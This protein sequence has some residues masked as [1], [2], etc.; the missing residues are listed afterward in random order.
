MAATSS[1]AAMTTPTPTRSPYS[2]S[3]AP[4]SRFYGGSGSNGGGGLEEPMQRTLLRYA[5]GS[6][7]DI[8]AG[9]E[10][11][12]PRT[13]VAAG[14][15][16]SPPPRPGEAEAPP[17]K[18][19]CTTPALPAKTGPTT[20]SP[21][22]APTPSGAT[23]GV[24]SWLPFT[25]S[26]RDRDVM[27]RIAAKCTLRALQEEREALEAARKAAAAAPPPAP[28]PPPP[29]PQTIVL[30][31]CGGH[32]ER[33]GSDGKPVPVDPLVKSTLTG[34][35]SSPQLAALS[36]KPAVNGTGSLSSARPLGIS[37]TTSLSP[38]T[39]PV[40]SANV[41]APPTA[42]VPTSAASTVPL[43]PT[44]A[45]PTP[46]PAGAAIPPA[47]AAAVSSASAASIPLPLPSASV[48]LG[49]SSHSTAAS[50]ATEKERMLIDKANKYVQSLEEEVAHK[51]KHL[52]VAAHQLAEEESRSI[53]L[54]HDRDVLLALHH[55][56]ELDN[57]D[58][59]Q[60]IEDV[61]A[62]R[63]REY[64]GGSGLTSWSRSPLFPYGYKHEEDGCRRV[65]GVESSIDVSQLPPEVRQAYATP[66]QPL[67]VGVTEAVG[68]ER[69]GT[70]TA[71]PSPAF[72]P[73]T[74]PP[75]P[76]TTATAPPLVSTASRP[77]L[78]STLAFAN[79]ITPIATPLPLP[80]APPVAVAAPLQP[81]APPTVT[82]LIPAPQSY[83]PPAPS[84]PTRDPSD[85]THNGSATSGA[86]GGVM[87]Q[88]LLSH[89]HL[90]APVVAPTTSSSAVTWPASTA[91]AT[92]GADVVP[93]SNTTT[94]GYQS[95]R[96]EELE[97]Y[98][99]ELFAAA[100][101]GAS[102]LQQHSGQPSS[103]ASPPMTVP[104]PLAPP[105]GPLVPPPPQPWSALPITPS[106]SNLGLSQPTSLTPGGKAPRS[107]Q[108][109]AAFS[110]LQTDVYREGQR[111]M[112]EAQRWHEF[113]R[114]RSL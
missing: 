104:T 21:P 85:D 44:T 108:W 2:P 110:Q 98:V 9:L 46:P 54:R 26:A 7:V 6:E 81:I 39:V 48:P 95:R 31:C 91:S 35:G 42:S 64:G 4:A 36:S 51:V 99:A 33:L 88:S 61:T 90:P 28:P 62:Q 82:P 112:A 78:P 94:L 11:G 73:V 55:Q 100:T 72:T 84:C 3:L 23:G 93:P 67:A 53:A 105:R 30:Q 102:Q 20:A 49:P 16:T 58:L 34:A 29:P 25:S 77:A 74:A 89:A 40:V 52:D 80:Q 37:P 79:P 76:A 69:Q 60:A 18:G 27:E 109:H 50:V 15:P 56:L 106:S 59:R 86:A 92:G 83:P 45:V 19:P 63:R 114:S 66:K 101:A 1:H 97:R 103:S 13:A 68:G 111:M 71:A 24:P 17:T 57:L 65:D 5:R 14:R 41:P 75:A 87:G 96:L 32:V 12:D 38:S 107:P 10:D 47:P 70:D 22:A 8:T 43:P 113:E